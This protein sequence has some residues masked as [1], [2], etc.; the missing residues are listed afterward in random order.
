MYLTEEHSI[1]Y[2]SNKD[3]FKEIDRYCFLAKNLSNT[4]NYLI[5]QCYRIHKKL[6]DG[7]ILDSREKGMIYRANC[8]IR[9]YNLK[10]PEK[11]QLPYIDKDNGFIADA[12]FL[13]FYMKTWKVYRDMPYATSTPGI[14]PGYRSGCRWHRACPGIL[15]R[16]SYS[17]SGNMHRQ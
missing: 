10:R 1:S 4:V 16:T 11:K 7:E 12:Y 6:Q 8:A 14:S 9:K 2:S 13:S 3:L 15:S 5:R 17:N